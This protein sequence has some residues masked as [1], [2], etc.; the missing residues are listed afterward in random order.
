M[1]SATLMEVAVEEFSNNNSE[2]NVQWFDLKLDRNL[3]DSSFE[4]YKLSLDPFVQYKL[5]AEK[6]LKLDTYNYVESGESRNRVFLYQHLKLF[7][8]QN[9]L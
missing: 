5:K 9:L 3:L 6:D 7:G 2:N 8:L 1:S 4:G